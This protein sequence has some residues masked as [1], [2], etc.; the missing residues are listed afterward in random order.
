MKNKIKNISII[1]PVLNE[2]ENIENLLNE[3]K[4][5]LYNKIG[6]EVVVVDDG[7][8]DGTIKNI[9]KILKNHS[10]LKLVVHKKNYG[11]SLSLRTG[12]INSKYDY[13][14]T[15][16]GDG[17]NDPSNILDL[18]SN[19]KNNI[20]FFLVIGNR[21]KRNDSFARRV[22]SRGA[23]FVRRL[24]L[25][26]DVPDTGCALKLFKKQ[27]FLYLPFFDHLHR[28]LPFLFLTMGGKVISINVNHRIRKSGVSKYS[29]LQRAVVG[30]YD[31][32]GVIWLRKRTQSSIVIKETCESTNNKRGKYGN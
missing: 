19:F 18:I 29:N 1:I 3:I 6:Y 12:I 13:I 31:L 22:A 15:L 4:T 17:Q 7:S 10:C 26:D 28:F 24:F 11:Q 32:F 20:P 5:N 8:T 27:E 23:F 30:I 14:V 16:D 21:K 2:E 9:K 25:N